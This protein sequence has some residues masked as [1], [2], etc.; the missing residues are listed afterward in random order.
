[1]TTD[2]SRATYRVIHSLYRRASGEHVIQTN[3]L[4]EAF[5]SEWHLCPR[6]RAELYRVVCEAEKRIREHRTS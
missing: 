1:M 2:L 5:A 6:D 3:T 4:I